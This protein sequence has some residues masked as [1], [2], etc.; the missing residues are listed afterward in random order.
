MDKKKIYLL[1]KNPNPVVHLEAIF[2]AQNSPA[3][4][5]FPLV[6]F[7]RI[8]FRLLTNIWTLKLHHQVIEQNV[9]AKNIQIMT[10][11]KYK[12]YVHILFFLQT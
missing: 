10:T 12:S 5:F 7:I 6:L 4:L 2:A 1:L 9:L 3:I 11:K 8:D